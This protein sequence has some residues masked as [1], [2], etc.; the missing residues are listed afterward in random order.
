M[1]D[2]KNKT[3][4]YQNLQGLNQK[5]SKYITGET[6]FINLQNLDARIPGALTSGPG[7]TQWLNPGVTGIITGIC[8]AIVRGNSN[9]M[10]FGSPTHF[11]AATTQWDAGN[12]STGSYQNVYTFIY[13]N[14]TNQMSFART[15]GLFCANQNDFFVYPS[16]KGE[17]NSSSSA[18]VVDFA[19]AR[20]F[21]LPKPRWDVHNFA[22]GQRA[23]ASN[24]PP[25][26][27]EAMALSVLPLSLH[28]YCL[29]GLARFAFLRFRHLKF[30]PAQA[31]YRP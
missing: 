6:E 5:V 11:I 15:N 24:S 7:T 16:E 28:F 19:N 21:S 30:T 13:P 27:L 31:C 18:M 17:L 9:G 12:I 10:G 20:Q 8:D 14:N 1:P 25:L 26:S 2:P 4:S 23:G 29:P 3:E 22:G